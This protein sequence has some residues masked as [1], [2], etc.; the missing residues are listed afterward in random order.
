MIPR[1][2][3]DS[4]AGAAK[5]GVTTLGTASKNQ[6][7]YGEYYQGQEDSGGYCD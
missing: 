2:A 5:A 1:G 3:V 6:I 4:I 7:A